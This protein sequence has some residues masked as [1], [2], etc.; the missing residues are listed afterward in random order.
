MGDAAET[1]RRRLRLR[2]RRRQRRQQVAMTVVDHLGELRSR[3]MVSLVAFVVISSVVFAFYE[4]IQE[5]FRAP[6]CQVPRRLLGPQG[7]KLIFT[8]PTEGFQFR[9][10]LTALVGLTLASPVWIYQLYAFI[11]PALTLKE[12][13]YS[14][15]FVFSSITLFAVGAVF[16]YLTLPTG[17]TFLIRLAGEGLTGFFSAESYLN[18]VGLVILAFGVTFQLPLVLFF[19]GLVGAVSVEQLRAQ[20]KVAVVAIF[21]LAAIVTPSQDPYTMSILALPLYGLYEVTILILARFL[22]KRAATS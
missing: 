20:R 5:F 10:K 4:P 9:L 17:V 21:A 8:K 14:L 18:F 11:V 12:K 15:P 13:R 19:L 2:F 3:L 16:A 6:L 1:R 22:K 7:C